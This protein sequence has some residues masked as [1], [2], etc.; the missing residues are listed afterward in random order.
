MRFTKTR[1]SDAE[2][3]YAISVLRILGRDR[4]VMA[5]EG[6]G[7]ALVLDDDL[8]PRVLANGQG[9]SMGSAPYPGHD[10]HLFMVTGF[11]PV[12]QSEGAGIDLC[13]AVDGFSTP[14]N[15]HRIID[16]PFV[17]RIATVAFGGATILIA[18]TVCGGKEYRDDWSK[19]GA[20]Y[21]IPIPAS[22]EGPWKPV[23]IAGGIHRNHGLNV[24]SLDGETLL[25]I[26][27]DEGVFAW[28]DPAVDLADAGVDDSAGAVGGASAAD[29]ADWKP[30]KILDAPISEIGAIDIDGDGADE[31]VAVEPF[32]GK[33]LA[34]YHRSVDGWSCVDRQPLDFGHGLSVGMLGDTPVAVVGNRAG[35][36]DLLCFTWDS[37]RKLLARHV[38]ESGVGTAGTTVF[39]DFIVASNPNTNEY[40]RYDLEASE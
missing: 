16:L 24:A 28:R 30:E 17:H 11:L 23:T 14:W 8:V 3:P 18:A 39:S 31:L 1:I 12:F 10:D 2:L 35:S 21:A 33:S 9:G 6:P 29:L 36:S 34:L 5:S 19:P 13:Y 38:V 7:P 15:Q 20:V 32:H 26:T 40:A 4:V 27:G 22:P 25:L 37:D